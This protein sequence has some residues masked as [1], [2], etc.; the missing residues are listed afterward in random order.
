MFIVHKNFKAAK[1]HL[2]K[3]ACYSKEIA[4]NFVYGKTNV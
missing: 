1:R 2:S 4:P 3:N